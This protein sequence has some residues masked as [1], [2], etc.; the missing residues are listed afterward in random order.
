MIISIDDHLNWW[1]FQLIIISIHH[2]L[3]QLMIIS[4]HHDLI[5][6]HYHDQN[7]LSIHSS[8]IQTHD[9][10]S[11]S[12]SKF[13]INPLTINSNWWFIIIIMIKIH[14]QS[15]HHQFN[16]II[17]HHYHY[18]NSLS[19]HT[20]SIQTTNSSS[21]SIQTSFHSQF[22][23]FSQSHLSQLHITSSQFHPSQSIL[24]IYA[25]NP[26][27]LAAIHCWNQ[28]KSPYSSVHNSHEV[29]NNTCAFYRT[30]QRES[31]HFLTGRRR[32][33]LPGKVDCST[34]Q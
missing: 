28:C 21:L 30:G 16:L 11:F 31:A 8:S 19:I 24:T 33:L 14:Y 13:I 23:S 6:H 2:H 1:S 18:Q 17:H 27:N 29:R 32:L 4:T 25:V 20:S 34:I 3:I 10:S 9:S 7:S 5:H 15:T 12:L 22:T 26:I